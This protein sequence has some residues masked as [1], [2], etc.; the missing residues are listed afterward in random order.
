[1]L[2][3]LENNADKINKNDILSITDDELNK[4]I[5]IICNSTTLNRLSLRINDGF[6]MRK[7]NNIQEFNNIIKNS[8]VNDVFD[9]LDPTNN[10]IIMRGSNNADIYKNKYLSYKMK[11]EKLKQ[12]KLE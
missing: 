7:F 12:K 4:M 1:M 5:E 11:Y 6:F 9:K 10:N 8:N 3:Y 2:N